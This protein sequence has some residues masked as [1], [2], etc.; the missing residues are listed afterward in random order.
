M[1]TYPPLRLGLLTSLAQM[2]KDLEEDPHLLKSP[3]CPYDQDVIDILGKLLATKVI[4]KQVQYVEQADPVVKKRGRPEKPGKVS[5]A[6]SVEVADEVRRILAQLEKLEPEDG[7]AD[8]TMALQILKTR[9]ALI[10]KLISMEERSYNI[11]KTSNFLQVVIQIL[12][13]CVSEDMRQVF[14][15]KIEPYRGES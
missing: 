1:A 8:K 9:T 7:M 15:K 2:K 4:E 14:L 5:D 12:D 13:D 11:K 6:G 10:E 3:D